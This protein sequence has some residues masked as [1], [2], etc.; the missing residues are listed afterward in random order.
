MAEKWLVARYSF[1]VNRRTEKRETRN[2]SLLQKDLGMPR[3]CSPIY[4][5]I[6][7]V[8]IGATW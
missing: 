1:L 6:K 4:E 7:L 3:T 2:E 8:E 5:R